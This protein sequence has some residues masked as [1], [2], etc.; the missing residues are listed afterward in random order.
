[1][2]PL[3]TAADRDALR[4]AVAAGELSAI[5]SDHQPHDADAKLLP[6]P[7]TAPGMSSLETLLPLALRLVSEG[8]LDLPSVIARLTSGPAKILGLDLGQL[9]PGATADVCVFDPHACWTPSAE[10]LLSHG[11]NTP[12]LGVE[13]QGRVVLTLLEGRVVYARG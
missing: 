9:T 7:E 8:V 13:M 2:P 10:T 11:V 3:R 4:Q 6:F 5:C 1:M 12:F